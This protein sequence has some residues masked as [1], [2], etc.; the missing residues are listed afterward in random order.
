MAR[1]HARKGAG[2]VTPKGLYRRQGRVDERSEIYPVWM[3]S[4]ETLPPW[5]L[6]FFKILVPF[7]HHPHFRECVNHD[8]T[9]P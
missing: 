3:S 2:E 7:P 8:D 5:G 9:V 6:Y 1:A 4:H